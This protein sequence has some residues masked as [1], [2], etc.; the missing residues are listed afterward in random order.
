[1]SADG[2]RETSTNLT[3]MLRCQWPAQ[4]PGNRRI[5]WYWWGWERAFHITITAI[6]AQTRGIKLDGACMCSMHPKNVKEWF[7]DDYVCRKQRLCVCSLSPC[8]QTTRWEHVGDPV[9]I[10]G[11]QEESILPDRWMAGVQEWEKVKMGETQS[12]PHWLSV[13]FLRVLNRL[14]LPK[15]GQ[16]R[17]RGDACGSPGDTRL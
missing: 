17:L 5:S 15:H 9:R 14:V 10:T 12:F 3:G 16:G 11:Q 6:T 2:G 13:R 7:S 1:M 4:S 8:E